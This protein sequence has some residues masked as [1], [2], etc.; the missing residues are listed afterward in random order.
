MI[1]S[2]GFSVPEMHVLQAHDDEVTSVVYSPDGTRFMTAGDDGFSRLW[3]SR[4]HKLIHESPR[5]DYGVPPLTSGT[6]SPDGKRAILAVDDGPPVVIDAQTGEVI[7]TLEGH[8]DEVLLAKFSSDGQHILTTGSVGDGQVIVRDA[9]TYEIQMR[10][11]DRGAV[12]FA[13]ISAKKRLLASGGQRQVLLLWGIHPDKTDYSFETGDISQEIEFGD[14]IYSGAFTPAGNL[15]IAADKYGRSLLWHIYDKRDVGFGDGATRLDSASFS[16]RHVIMGDELIDIGRRPP[17]LELKL[18]REGNGGFSTLSPDGNYIL[19]GGSVPHV[20]DART[21]RRVATL[22]GQDKGV[23]GVVLSASF[24]PRHRGLR[25]ATASRDGTVHF[26][27]LHPEPKFDP[28]PPDAD[29]VE[30]E[31]VQALLDR[32]CAM[33]ERRPLDAGWPCSDLVGKQP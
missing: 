29:V 8:E 1:R 11:R 3:D 14:W 26:W 31:R 30:T 21:G 7:R 12:L 19:T 25:V 5:D 23:K 13:D 6:F 24:N 17:Q 27:D 32:A 20:W 9:E 28:L 16:D 4:T 15:V 22:K 33:L 10:F 18:P 2:V